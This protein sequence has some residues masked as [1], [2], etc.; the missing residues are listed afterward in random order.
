[1]WV[2]LQVNLFLH[3]IKSKRIRLEEDIEPKLRS[4]EASEM[5]GDELLYEAYEDVY[6]AAVG[7][8][9]QQRR[10]KIV[11]TALRWVLCAFRTLTLRELAY[12]TSVESDGSSASSVQE[13]LL[14][15]FCSNLLIED[16]RGIIRLPHLSVRHYLEGRKPSMFDQELTHL[17]AALSCLYFA[18][19]PRYHEIGQSQ[20]DVFQH[21]NVTL[22]R[23]FYSYV[24]LYWALHCRQ[25]K[26]TEDF[27]HLMDTFSE[28]T[29]ASQFKTLREPSD[30]ENVDRDSVP[31]SEVP[32]VPRLKAK[33]DS[34]NLWDEANNQLINEDGLLVH[35][36]EAILE[37]LTNKQISRGDDLGGKDQFGRTSLHDAVRFRQM[38]TTIALADAGAPLDAQDC[39]GNAPIHF[40]AI[41]GFDDGIKH[42]LLAGADKDAR[43]LRGETPLHLAILFEAQSVAETLISV[44]ADALAK[45]HQGNTPFH[46]A[47][48]ADDTSTTEKL[49]L[50]GY[51]PDGR[52]QNDDSALSLAIKLDSP[53]LTKLLLQH[54]A[55]LTDEDRALLTDTNSAEIVGTP[56]SHRHTHF[57]A[58]NVKSIEVEDNSL[59][60]V[61][62][63]DLDNSIPPCESCRVAHWI[64]TS[65]MG[66]SHKYHP[67]VEHLYMSA[68]T[69]CPLCVFFKDEL[70]ERA[71]HGTFDQEGQLTITIDPS[72]TQGS[73]LD[74]K[75]IFV[76]CANDSPLLTYELCRDQSEY[77][78]TNYL[79][80]D[81]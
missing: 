52:N 50:M 23:S 71:R 24:K 66:A 40:A 15:E 12:A 28:Q 30:Q 67:S 59:Y 70:E 3:E 80:H 62:F 10:K 64:I 48:A 31:P 35:N 74:R 54:G 49:L 58:D 37:S 46:Y 4:L 20:N 17:Q 38:N 81:S 72:F 11:T 43:N 27:G 6:D 56:S 1:M 25:A 13:G 79:R 16:S 22:T 42:L 32:S 19:S 34:S 78:R 45:D 8:T 26:K 47:A 7:G 5:V 53:A 75:D 14:L 73:K 55:A 41:Y 65:R 36:Y 60:S 63:G 44:S 76:L 21:G 68:E 57:E 2:K 61:T 9:S 33:D 39:D 18:N 77:S 29:I 69:G 51:N